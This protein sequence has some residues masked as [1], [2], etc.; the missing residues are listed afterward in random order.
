[1]ME[2]VWNDFMVP[3]GLDHR[4]IQCRMS[5][6][7]RRTK[8]EGMNRCGVKDS[9]PKTDDQGSHVGFHHAILAAMSTRAFSGLNDF[10]DVLLT[11]GRVG[12]ASVKLRQR[13]RESPV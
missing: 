12:G 3:G 4:C 5:L 13:F 11:A 1:M 2:S 10:E 9:K 6:K 8:Q 7:R